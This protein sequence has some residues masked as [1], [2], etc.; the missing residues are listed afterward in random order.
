MVIYM[1]YLNETERKFIRA[2]LEWKKFD[3]SNPSQVKKRIID[4]IRVAPEEIEG[5]VEDISLLKEYLHIPDRVD[6]KVPEKYLE[7]KDLSYLLVTY[8]M[9]PDADYVEIDLLRLLIYLSLTK[10]TGEGLILERDDKGR[11]KRHGELKGFLEDIIDIGGIK[12]E[13][14]KKSKQERQRWHKDLRARQF[15]KSNPKFKR[16]FLK[17]ADEYPEA[18]T[19]AWLSKELIISQSWIT[20]LAKTMKDKGILEE[21]GEGWRISRSQERQ[22][23]Y[24]CF[25][26]RKRRKA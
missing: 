8:G 22:I 9:V 13:S 18:R 14:D 16:L 10:M 25:V 11:F 1:P 24:F 15:I 19:S 7:D 3:H 2:A 12:V 6:M 5:F 23:D 4:K 17:L 26:S 21:S 20:R